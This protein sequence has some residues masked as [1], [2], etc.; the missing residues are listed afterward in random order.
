VLTITDTA[1][2][3]V[4]EVLNA[5]GKPHWGLRVFISGSGCCGPAYGMDI[6]E[7]PTEEDEV[8]E[9]NGLKVFVDKDTLER[10][11]GMEIDFVDD[12]QNQGFIIRSSQPPSCG[13]SSC[14]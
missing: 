5:E 14:G 9:K 2:E 11:S 3:K 1:V 10:L 8:I 12:G 7:K 13:C 6:E 4:K